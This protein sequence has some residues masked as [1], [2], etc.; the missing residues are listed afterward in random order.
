MEDRLTLD[1]LG[2]LPPGRKLGLTL[3]AANGKWQ[4]I[5]L[6]APLRSRAN[7][8]VRSS[9]MGGEEAAAAAK[10]VLSECWLLGGADTGLAGPLVRLGQT[11][12]WLWSFP[13]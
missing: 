7:C 11:V 5:S 12:A 4:L 8:K 6:A 13:P 2:I 9:N 1:S 10:S 3:G